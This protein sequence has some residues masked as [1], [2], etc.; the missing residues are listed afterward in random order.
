MRRRA[1]GTSPS[2]SSANSG[3]SLRPRRRAQAAVEPVRPRVVRALQ[4]AALARAARDDRA[5]VPAHVGERAQHVVAVARE[6]DGQPGDVRRR[7]A[8]P[9]AVSSSRRPAYCHARRKIRSRSRRAISGSS[10]QDQ[11]IVLIRRPA[12]SRASSGARTGAPRPRSAS[13]SVVTRK[14]S[15]VAG[16]LAAHLDARAPVAALQLDV[17]LARAP[18]PT[19]GRPPSAGSGR[20]CA[21]PAASRCR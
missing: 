9:G 7:V 18:R 14:R 8:S 10:Y 11:G 17:D 13:S 21:R 16:H 3:S 12:G 5:A 20:R 1:S 4:R 6:H 15:A 2:P 19:A